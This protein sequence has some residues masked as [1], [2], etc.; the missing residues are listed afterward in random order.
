MLKIK[1]ILLFFL[2]L[3]LALF[4]L[5]SYAGNTYMKCW[6]NSDGITECGNR[7]P[8]EYYNQR[9]RSIDSRGVTRDIK[10]RARTKEERIAAQEAEKKEKALQAIKNETIR[11]KKMR[12]D[13]LLKTYLTVD[14]ILASLNSKLGLTTSRISILEDS[15]PVKKQKFDNLVKEAANMERSGKKV[16]DNLIA[17]LNA[18]RT[19]IKNTKLQIGIE[20]N[21]QSNIKKAYR[22]D[23]ERFVFLKTKLLGNRAKTEQDKEKLHIAQISCNDENQCV[24]LCKQAHK[25]VTQFSSTEIVYQ[26][27]NFTV[28]NSPKKHDDIAMTLSLQEDG[29]EEKKKIIVLHIR[30]HPERK[31]RELCSSDTVKNILSDFRKFNAP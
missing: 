31:G 9:I 7:V 30:C 13:I 2:S 17:E 18:L 24:E 15:I 27:D 5:H 1:L 10:K 16:S 26:S 22:V 20:E 4:T 12:D 25:F 28:S 6:K 23:I 3:Y 8:R 29:V 11:R 19:D 21:K 14:D